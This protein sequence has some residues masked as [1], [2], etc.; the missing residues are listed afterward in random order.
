MWTNAI[1]DTFAG[2]IVWGGLDC[3]FSFTDGYA[4]K[5]IPNGMHCY[6]SRNTSR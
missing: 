2:Y 4:L 5:I 3:F 1:K 6:I